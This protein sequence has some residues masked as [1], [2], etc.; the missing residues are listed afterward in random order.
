MVDNE[1]LRRHYFRC[2]LCGKRSHAA[3]RERPVPGEWGERFRVGC[4]KC[5]GGQFDSDYLHRLAASLGCRPMD[6]LLRADELLKDLTVRSRRTDSTGPTKPLPLKPQIDQ[7]AAA[8]AGPPLDYLTARGISRA[9]LAQHK[10][11]LRRGVLVFP[12]FDGLGRVAGIKY[13]KPKAGAQMLAPSGRGRDWPLYPWPKAASRRP[14]VICAGEL[15]A[16]CALSHGVDT[17]SVTLGANYWAERWTL[18]VQRR[19]VVLVFDNNERVQARR[20]GKL[21]AAR[22][23][24]VELVSLRRLGLTEAKADLT[25]YFLAGGEARLLLRRA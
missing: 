14:L 8:L 9:V 15:D 20:V 19:R 4:I 17:C 10:V 21:L 25:D 16:L 7:W 2:P 22:G 24:K 6:L 13:R 3:Y 5:D 12:M 11:G 1:R 23:V 18:A